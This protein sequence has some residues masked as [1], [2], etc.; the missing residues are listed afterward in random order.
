M[1]KNNKVTPLK[2]GVDYRTIGLRAFDLVLFSGG[3]SGVSGFIQCLEKWRVGEGDFSHVGMII[4][5]EVLPFQGLKENKLYIFESTQSGNLTDGVVNIEGHAFLG[6]QIRDFD[7]VMKG[8]DSNPNSSIAVRRLIDNP[9]D[10]MNIN[11]VKIIMSYLYGRYNHKMY[12]VDILQLFEAMIPSLRKFRSKKMED[13]FIFCSELVATIYKA[14]NI[15]PSDANPSDVVPMDF[16]AE[17]EDH[18]VDR[19][20]FHPVQYIRYIL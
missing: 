13:K 2:Q 6:S 7:L 11:N 1:F 3:K 9:L 15:L 20:K 19:T 14:Y 18:K 17:D 10:T 5:S 12:E 16:V 8:Y 4:T